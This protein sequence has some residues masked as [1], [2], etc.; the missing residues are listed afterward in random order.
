[1]KKITISLFF[2]LVSFIGF[3]STP[4]GEADQYF[5]PSSNPTIADIVVS[6]DNIV[7]FATD[8]STGTPLPET[9]ELTAETTYYAFDSLD[10]NAGSL[11]VT[12][13]FNESLPAPVGETEQYFCEQD[14]GTI[15]DLQVYNTAG[16]DYIYWYSSEDQQAGTLL[17]NNTL[18]EDNTTYY[19][20]QGMCCCYEPL[21]I[22]V[23]INESIPAPIGEIDEPSFCLEENFTLADMPVFNT[24]GFDTI[25]WYSTSNQQAGT[26]LDIS[27]LLED[28][29]TYYAF[30][31]TSCSEP[32]A[33]TVHL[34]EDIPAP[35]VETEEPTFCEEDN[36]TI[37]DLEAT[38]T[39]GYTS[40]FWATDSYCQG[41]LPINPTTPLE[42][43]ETY[44]AYQ[45][46]DNGCC[47][48]YV[49]V[50]AILEPCLSINDNQVNTFSLSPNPV[51]N[52][53]NLDFNTINDKVS[54]TIYNALGK[55]VYKNTFYNKEHIAIDLSTLPSGIYF[56]SSETDKVIK[57]TKFIKN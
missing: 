25:Y 3:S 56:I 16:Y 5:C 33:I 54:L 29:T 36:P 38:N 24:S 22:T 21:A 46:Y 4:T 14:N 55:F 6:G 57:T 43:G 42:N 49:T 13:H 27:T 8:D 45:T 41:G 23:H 1:M 40:I 10:T 17:D 11:A 47:P 50:T 18:L 26:L 7:W 51:K 35:I 30:Q 32:L 2:L 53:L 12:V 52:I 9:Q 39:D 37:A 31:G 19:A 34:I 44:Y 20:F 48:G 28:N 15:A